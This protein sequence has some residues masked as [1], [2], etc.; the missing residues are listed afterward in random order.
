MQ[1]NAAEAGESFPLTLL[2]PIFPLTVVVTVEDVSE[3]ED[4][5]GRRGS[6]DFSTFLLHLLL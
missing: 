6:L 4:G 1:G 2:L 5:P 3:Q